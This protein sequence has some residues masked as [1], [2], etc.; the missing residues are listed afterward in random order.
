LEVFINRQFG[1]WF[2]SLALNL[3]RHIGG[4]FCPITQVHGSALEIENAIKLPTPI[5]GNFD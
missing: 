5:G 2:E 3:N 4:D 1:T